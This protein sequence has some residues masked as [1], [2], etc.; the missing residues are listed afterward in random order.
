MQVPIGMADQQDRDPGATTLQLASDLV[1]TVAR[2]LLGD[3]F[4]DKVRGCHAVERQRCCASEGLVCPSTH[5]PQP[6]PLQTS[7]VR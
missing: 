5:K 2:A 1:Y 4:G 3:E 7:V 6:K